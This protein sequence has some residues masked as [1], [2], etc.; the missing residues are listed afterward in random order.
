MASHLAECNFERYYMWCLIINMLW[1]D[2]VFNTGMTCLLNASSAALSKACS[3]WNLFQSICFKTPG[4]IIAN[5]L[6]Y[7]QGPFTF[8][9]FSTIFIPVAATGPLPSW[10]KMCVC[11]QDCLCETNFQLQ[12]REERMTLMLT[13][14]VEGRSP[15]YFN[16][17]QILETK[18]MAVSKDCRRPH[19]HLTTFVLPM[20]PL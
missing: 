8:S 12:F 18:R 16:F 11:V 14:L 1:L 10:K 7:L 13:H 3:Y 6:L 20:T 4:K 17:P 2:A 19:L 9:A 15:Q 5:L